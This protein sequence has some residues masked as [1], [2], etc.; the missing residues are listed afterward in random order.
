MKSCTLEYTF[1]IKY[2][3]QTQILKEGKKFMF[4]INF[5]HKKVEIVFENCKPFLSN[6]ALGYY[7]TDGVKALTK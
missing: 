3:S 2:V 6:L 4:D 1:D 5:S 7:K